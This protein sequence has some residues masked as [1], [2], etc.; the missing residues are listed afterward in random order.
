MR[1][2]FIAVGLHHLQCI[3]TSYIKIRRLKPI[4]DL[5]YIVQIRLALDWFGTF[6]ASFFNFL[7]YYRWSW[8]TDEGSVP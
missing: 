8:M 6:E 7:N 1:F 3:Y 2:G 5:P 4:M